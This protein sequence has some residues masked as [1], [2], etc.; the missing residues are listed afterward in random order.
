MAT[1]SLFIQLPR[2]GNVLDSIVSFLIL[3]FAPTTL[4]H[5]CFR[6]LSTQAT[7]FFPKWANEP[8]FH[9]QVIIRIGPIVPRH[10]AIVMPSDHFLAVYTK[11][12]IIKCQL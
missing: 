12:G 10:M 8:H 5:K 6:A 2:L 9:I 11:A 4:S 1:E 7:G 3:A